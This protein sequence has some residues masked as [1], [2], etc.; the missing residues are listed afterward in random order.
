MMRLRGGP[1]HDRGGI[2]AGDIVKIGLV[3]AVLWVA[4]DALGERMPDIP[5]LPDVPTN[6]IDLEPEPA[7]VVAAV[8][9]ESYA[10][11]V[12]FDVAC[13]KIVSAA[14]DVEGKKTGAE[15]IGIDIG[16]GEFEKKIFGDFLLC[17]DS[18]QVSDSARAQETIDPITQKV[19][20][21]H[22]VIDGLQVVHPRIDYLDPRNCIDGNPGDSMEEIQR[23]LDEYQQQIADGEQEGC[24]DGFKVTRI[25][26][27]DSL[28][29]V[30]DIGYRGAQ[31]ALT[32]DS[33]PTEIIADADA[34]YA[35]EIKEQL[36]SQ[37][38]YAS[39]NVV[40]DVQRPSDTE[41][42]QQQLD[43]I[44]SDLTTTFSKVEFGVD[45]DGQYIYVE[46]AGGSHATVHFGGYADLSVDDLT[47]SE[48]SNTFGSD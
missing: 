47:I 27:D 37:A 48:P 6:V 16:N 3:G 22:I 44:S 13:K 12:D 26:G 33:N 24:D 25:G 14:V 41:T 18:T 5:G 2:D 9:Q 32:L 38:R 36:E 17:G 29:E 7:E 34:E 10:V 40:V 11:E 4:V 35:Q 23:K 1:E 42:V 46:D 45:D 20:G 15:F 19:T 43:F 8:D 39:V 28:A 31:L 21:L 30:K